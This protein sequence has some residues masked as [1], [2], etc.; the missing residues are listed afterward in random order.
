L[1]A[2]V[3]HG[4]RDVRID[5]KPK[6]RIEQ[7]EDAIVR[8]TTTAICGSDLHL[9]HGTVEG[10]EPGQ[11]LG[12]EF[13][14]V[15][16]EIG[17]GVHEVKVGD[18]VIIPFNI[19]CGLCWHCR[20][21]LFSACE[22]SNPKGEAG[23]AYGYTQRLGGY[24]GGQAEYVRVPFANFNPVKIPDGLDDEHV[25][26]LTDVLCTG[27]FGVDIAGS[28]SDAMG[29]S[30]GDDVAVFGAGPV[31]Y[32]AVMS[33]L[34]L[35][36]AAKVFS[37]D[38][39]ENRL[40][41]TRELGARTINFDKEDPEEVIKKETDGHGAVCVDA[42]GYEAVGHHSHGDVKDPASDPQNP[43]QVLEWITKA[44]RLGSIVGIP[45]VYV[46]AYNNFPI[47]QFFEHGLQM[48]MGQCPVKKYIEPLL[49]L[50]ETNRIDPT[51]LISHRMKLEE[52]P[53]AYKIWD[54]KS[55]AT[56]IVL[57]P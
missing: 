38:H 13:V 35:R 36:G 18:R 33:A 7:P 25:L 3:Y 9:Y 41:L 29:I 22:R 23:G 14:G 56:K 4:T 44:A 21:N 8:V 2:L 47:G 5:D 26:F 17:P 10:M 15:I 45:G 16:D 49:H 24:D 11:T 1:E 37:V 6:P 31:G 46:S 40:K 54:K 30:P 39:F 52:A 34:K 32:F 55:E 57:T 48:K 27:Y 28:T 50:I 42:V 53:E 20:H 51:A 19:A 43:V 12:H